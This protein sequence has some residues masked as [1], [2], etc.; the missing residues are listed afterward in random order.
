[1]FPFVVNYFTVE[2]GIDRSVIEV[3]ELVNEIADHFVASLRE[4]L[5]MNDINIQNM[6]SIGADNTNVNYGRIHSVFS[7]LKSDVPNL[8][9]GNCFSH[10]LNNAVK[11]SHTRLVIDVE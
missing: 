2:R 4:V 8:M 6:T 11:T 1:M 10:V 7:L 3:I 9:K 5:Q